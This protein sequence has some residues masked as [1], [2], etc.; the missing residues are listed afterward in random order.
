MNI[1]KNVWCKK[2]KKG[3][4]KTQGRRMNRNENSA[5]NACCVSTGRL[6]RKR[7]VTG[8]MPSGHVP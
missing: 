1:I 4:D 5:L 7:K 2:R 3:Y 8:I 6:K